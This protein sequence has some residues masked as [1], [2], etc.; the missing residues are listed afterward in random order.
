MFDINEFFKR[1]FVR[2]KVCFVLCIAERVVDILQ[3]DVKG[4]EIA[5]EALDLSW[6]WEEGVDVSG[7]KLAEFV[8]SSTEKDLGEREIY[9]DEGDIKIPALIVVTLG[10]GY[11]ARYAYEMRNETDMPEPIWEITDD[12]I[13]DIID[14]AAKAG[15]SD[16]QG[17]LKRLSK[18]NFNTGNELGLSC[19]RYDVLL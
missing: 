6:Q 3:S 5:K 12:S 19:S 17:I 4:Y 16:I 18:K 11:V 13:S 7:D 8:D 14:F 2:E 9:Y 10:V 15:F 1:A